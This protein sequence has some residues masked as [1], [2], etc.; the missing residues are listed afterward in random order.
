MYNWTGL[1]LRKAS[2]FRVLVL[3]GFIRYVCICVYICTDPYI[4]FIGLIRFIGS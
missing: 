1:L 2:R 3:C 4:G